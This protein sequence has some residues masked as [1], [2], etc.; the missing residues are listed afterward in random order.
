VSGLAGRRFVV[1]G[2]TSGIGR[3]TAQALAAL[4]G[5]VVVHGRDAAV[6]EAV[7]RAIVASTHNERVTGIVADFASLADVR[8]MA[9]DLAFRY[10]SIDV[11][12]NNAGTLASA[13]RT[14]A[15]GFEWQFGVNHLAPFLLTSLLLDMLGKSDAGRIVNV[16]SHA[17]RGA[18]LDF[19]DLQSERGKYR[20]FRAYGASK[21]ANVLFTLELSRRLAGTSTTANSL[22]PGAVATGIFRAGGS[23]GKVVMLLARP[24]L[25]SPTEGAATS[26]YLATSP[27]VAGVTG[28]YFAKCRAVA[29]APAA[30]DAA[31]A[32]RLWEISERLVGAQRIET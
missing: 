29:P 27:E 11:L 16:A 30:T 8:R 22:H 24:F 21:L 1:T 6:V 2:A 13:R 20:G 28:K 9:A 5:A 17:H 3:E 15:D 19:D 26:V 32:A 25:L 23:I 14:T 7:R 12:V 18:T 10:P 4:G 31:A